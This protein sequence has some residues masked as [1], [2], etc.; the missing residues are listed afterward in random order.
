MKVLLSMCLISLSWS[1]PP[2]QPTPTCGDC[3]ALVTTIAA[4]LTTQ[5]G[6]AHQVEVLLAKVCPKSSDPE[7]CQELLPAFWTEIAESLWP[8]YYNPEAVWM[9]GGEGACGGPDAR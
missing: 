5:E 9:C 7:K 6:L 8:N 1:Q 4:S 2:T 3:S